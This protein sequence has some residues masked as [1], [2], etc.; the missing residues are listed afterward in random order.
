LNKEVFTNIHIFKIQVTE[1]P[2]QMHFRIPFFYYCFSNSLNHQP[3]YTVQAPVLII[4]QCLLQTSQE[5]PIFF[6][7][8]HLINIINCLSSSGQTYYYLQSSDKKQPYKAHVYAESQTQWTVL[9]MTW[10]ETANT[11]EFHWPWMLIFGTSHCSW[12]VTLTSLF[13]HLVTGSHKSEWQKSV[14]RVNSPHS[15]LIRQITTLSS[16]KLSLALRLTAFKLK[17]LRLALNHAAYRMLPN[18]VCIV[19]KESFMLFMLYENTSFFYSQYFVSS[20]NQTGICAC[21]RVCVCS[22]LTGP[23]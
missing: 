19:L 11:A 1:T 8:H 3:L 22:S 10:N 20:S 13:R 5:I 14:W 23:H 9:S 17:G 15:L 6:Y 7:P 18:R 16:L 21:V 2:F 4:T 12:P